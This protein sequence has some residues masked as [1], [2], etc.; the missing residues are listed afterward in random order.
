MA[1]S[2]FD[3]PT[4]VIFG[5]GSVTELGKESKMLEKKLWGI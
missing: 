2:I 5:V 1:I 3:F 4:K